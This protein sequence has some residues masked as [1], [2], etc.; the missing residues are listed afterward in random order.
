MEKYIILCISFCMILISL[1]S[2][3]EMNKPR[4]GP[5]GNGTFSTLYCVTF[6]SILIA[7]MCYFFYRILL[8]KRERK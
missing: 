1:I 8:F 4:L 5:V 2:M 3:Y 7:G 6:I